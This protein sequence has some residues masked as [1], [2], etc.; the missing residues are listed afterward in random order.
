M[1]HLRQKR[2]STSLSPLAAIFAVLFSSGLYADIPRLADGRPDFQGLWTNETDTPVERPPQFADRQAMTDEEAAAWRPGSAAGLTD[3]TQNEILDPNRGPP[4][5]GEPIR[6]EADWFF[7]SAYVAQIHGEYRTSLVIDPPNGRIP[8][9]ENGRNRDFISQMLARPGVAEF[10]GPELRP[11]GERCLL[12]VLSTAGP[13]M[14]PM[15]YNSN[16]RIV[17]TTDYVMIMA[18]MVNDVRIIRLDDMHQH[19]A[20][21]KWMGDSVGHWE[22]DTLVVTTR[23]IHPQQSFRGSTGNMTSTEWFSM[24]SDGQINYRVTINEPEVFGRSWTAEVPMRRLPADSRIYEYACHEGN[25]AIVGAL[26]GAR[27][28]E[29]YAAQEAKGEAR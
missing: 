6:L 17:Q 12:S 25:Y 23:N 29:H 11:A 5:K 20:I 13:P 2:C 4:P 22:G 7:S 28:Q 14:L 8:Y 10:D 19:E 3:L 26:S 16:Y 18:E 24:E 21:H 15:S 27:W 9:A 1:S